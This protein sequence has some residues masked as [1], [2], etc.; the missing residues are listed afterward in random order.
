MKLAPLALTLALA[1]ALMVPAAREVR[2]DPTGIQRC[3][4]PDGTTVYTDKPCIRFGASP[5]AMPDSLRSRL[6]DTAAPPDSVPYDAMTAGQPALAGAPAALHPTTGTPV[7]RRSQLA[8]CAR[9]PMQLAMD[10]QGSIALHDVNRLA[11]SYHWTG[12]T[13]EESVPLMQ[14]LGSI[15]AQQVIASEYVDARLGVGSGYAS[16]GVAMPG[17]GDGGHAGMVLLTVYG[18]GGSHPLRLN[19]REYA[20]CYFAYF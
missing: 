20:G 8:G 9:S 6:V 13:T 2:A 5:D 18:D 1:A 4:A 11:E 19:V 16:N 10:M 3:T 12:I 7:A 14:R 17:W 15:A